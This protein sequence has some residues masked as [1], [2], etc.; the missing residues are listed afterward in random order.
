[1]DF[2]R[3]RVLPF[4]RPQNPT[5]RRTEITNPELVA[6]ESNT[7]SARRIKANPESST[8]R[9]YRWTSLAQ[10]DARLSGLRG[11]GLALQLDPYL[12][13]LILLAVQQ[14][15]CFQQDFDELMGIRRDRPRNRT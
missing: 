10:H 14:T 15:L 3:L 9:V 12:L 2:L 5:C 4:P 8:K 7:D 11:I 13:D 1:M 6:R